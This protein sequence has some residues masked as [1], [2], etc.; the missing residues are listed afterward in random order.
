LYSINL[1]SIKQRKKE[2]LMRLTP[3][4]LAA[5]MLTLSSVTRAENLSEA[6]ALARANDPQL[7]LADAAQ[8]VADEAIVQARSVLLPQANATVS[9]SK[10]EGS[11]PLQNDQ[12]GLIGTA[13]VSS[14]SKQLDL[15]VNQSIY[16]HADYTASLFSSFDHARFT[17]QRA[18]RS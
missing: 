10:S 3:I 7:Q 1:Y 4:A 6:Y 8:R 17:H 9:A 18:G 12:N 2:K 14:T 15:Q 16:D 11:S 5:L 13:D